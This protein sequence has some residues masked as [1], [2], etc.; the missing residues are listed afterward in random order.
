M[1]IEVILLSK[2][3]H[4]AVNT[5]LSGSRFFSGLLIVDLAKFYTFLRLAHPQIQK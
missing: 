4:I 3:K 1:K 2:T 5:I